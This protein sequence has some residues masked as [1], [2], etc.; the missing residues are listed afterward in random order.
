[1]LI[2]ERK[3]RFAAGLTTR[4]HL[5]NLKKTINRITKQPA[6]MLKICIS[7]ICINKG[8][9]SFTFIKRRTAMCSIECIYEAQFTVWCKFVIYEHQPY[10]HQSRLILMHHLIISTTCRYPTVI[11][12]NR[13]LH[14]SLSINLLFSHK[15]VEY[16]SE[17]KNEKK[18]K[19]H[20]GPLVFE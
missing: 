4:V 10:E 3:C 20:P 17:K 6:C 2:W 19:K 8:H 7:I 14:S 5:N 11:S 18:K 12:R 16:T 9:S 13:A 15:I 1:M